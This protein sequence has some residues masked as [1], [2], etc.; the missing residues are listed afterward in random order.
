MKEADVS[1]GL[2][3]FVEQ[4]KSGALG[5]SLADPEGGDGQFPPFV[6]QAPVLL[7]LVDQCGLEV[8][9]DLPANIFF[10]LEIIKLK[11]G[12]WVGAAQ[13]GFTTLPCT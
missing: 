11:L 4:L 9:N 3:E 12:R 2:Q 5:M 6:S 10:F 13:F 1:G 7:S 8:P